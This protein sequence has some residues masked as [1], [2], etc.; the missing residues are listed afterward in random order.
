MREPKFKLILYVEKTNSRQALS[1]L[2][3]A[4]E[5][6]AYTDY[7]LTIVDLSEKPELHVPGLVKTP[8]LI[9][10]SSDTSIISSDLEN[11]EELRKV[12]GFNGSN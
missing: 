7:E 12:F 9:L 2:Y 4:L 8:S 3:K 1:H 5:H 6:H 10:T 11:I